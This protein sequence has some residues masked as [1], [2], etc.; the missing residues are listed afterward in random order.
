MSGGPSQAQKN[1]QA[2]LQAQLAQQQA[3]LLKKRKA[4]SAVALTSIQRELRGNSGTG[5]SDTLG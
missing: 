4:A 5:Q 1:Q 2:A 3:E